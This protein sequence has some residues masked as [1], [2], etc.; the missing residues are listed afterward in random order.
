[1]GRLNYQSPER[2]TLSLIRA[3]T[4]TVTR[5]GRPVKKI[6]RAGN[7]EVRVSPEITNPKGGI[8]SHLQGEEDQSVDGRR[9]LGGVRLGGKKER[10]KG[11]KK[12][13]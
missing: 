4:R 2:G 11:E 3:G 7:T 6:A 1:V 13:C 10:E 8:D 5:V 12:R 9:C